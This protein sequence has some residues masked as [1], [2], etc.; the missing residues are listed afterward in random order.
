[1][2]NEETR[3]RE[4]IQEESEES[5]AMK[6][7]RGTGQSIEAEPAE[8][9]G[10]KVSKW[11]NFWYHHKWHAGIFIGIAVI[12]IVLAVQIV[13]HKTPDVYMMYAGPG[14]M[15]GDQYKRFEQAVADVMDDYDKNGYKA[16][17][18]SDNTYLTKEQME[19][20]RKMGLNVDEAANRAAYERYEMEIMAGE[21]MFCMLDPELYRSVADVG[22]FEPLTEIF[23][24]VPEGAV[25]EYGVRLGDTDFYNY[26]PDISF[27][28]PDTI[29]A[30]RV[31][32][33]LTFRNDEKKEAYSER[34][35]QLFRD[36]VDFDA[37]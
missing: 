17:S 5:N 6:V 3:N 37:E 14:A 18:F 23:G 9:D 20:R 19:A 12:A 36:I 2:K 31:H 24:E 29:L 15:V 30:V 35:R 10:V 1:M 33:T 13:T 28:P 4:T 27:I 8:D 21:H 22:G 11:E 7:I 16:I 34:H 32:T 25:D 26:N